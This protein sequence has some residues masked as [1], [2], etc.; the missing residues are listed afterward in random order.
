[1]RKVRIGLV[2]RNRR[3]R[4]FPLLHLRAV[5]D[6]LRRLLLGAGINVLYVCGNGNRIGIPLLHRGQP[7]PE[8]HRI[9]PF[10]A[11]LR[12]LATEHRPA[13]VG[14]QPPILL[15]IDQNRLEYLGRLVVLLLSIQFTGCRQLFVL[16]GKTRLPRRTLLLTESR[17]PVHNR[18]L[19]GRR[20]FRLLRCC[21]EYARSRNRQTDHNHAVRKKLPVRDFHALFPPYIIKSTVPFF[22]SSIPPDQRPRPN[23]T[24]YASIPGT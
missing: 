23:P 13:L 2:Q 4:L 21:L 14:D 1:M 7:R 19:C 17:F 6:Q 9:R 11:D 22:F 8:H 3:L 24:P 16:R 12:Q 5:F 18:F 10:T 15:K 20:R